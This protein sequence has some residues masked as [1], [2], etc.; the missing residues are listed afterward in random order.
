[1]SGDRPGEQVIA[2]S[3]EKEPCV[4]AG[5]FL[6]FPVGVFRSR[7]PAAESVRRR[8]TGAYGRT[9]RASRACPAGGSDVTAI[10][11][12]KG[13]SDRLRYEPAFSPAE[14]V[15]SGRRRTG[16]VLPETRPSGRR[17]APAPKL[18][19]AERYE[20]DGQTDRQYPY[21]TIAYRKFPGRFFGR[22][23]AAAARDA[24]L[25]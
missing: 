7:F 12:R 22:V 15:L 23:P 20:I 21:Y 17:G 18:Q 16:K 11:A 14:Q 6:F 9:G 3:N 8:K 24:M 2:A 25:A 5:S 10:L 19:H 4:T 1:M 13:V